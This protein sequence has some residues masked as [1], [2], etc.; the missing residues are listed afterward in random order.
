VTSGALPEIQPRRNPTRPPAFRFLRKSPDPKTLNFAPTNAEL[1]RAVGSEELKIGLGPP[2]PFA[3]PRARTGSWVARPIGQAPG[4][5]LRS[6][7]PAK[8]SDWPPN[9]GRSARTVSW[10]FHERARMTAR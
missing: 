10:S 1:T 5:E 6:A 4:P 8:A 2:T 9:A 3:V 7:W